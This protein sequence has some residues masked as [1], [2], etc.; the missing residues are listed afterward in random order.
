MHTKLYISNGLYYICVTILMWCMMYQSFF[1]FLY[2]SWGVHRPKNIR[3]GSP[4]SMYVTTYL[5]SSLFMYTCR[6]SH[7]YH[8]SPLPPLLVYSDPSSLCVSFSTPTKGKEQRRLQAF[9]IDLSIYPS[10][11]AQP[12]TTIDCYKTRQKT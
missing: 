10:Y 8:S 7:S 3:T 6:C 4:L 2:T 12:N 5:S 9:S 1:E 11:L